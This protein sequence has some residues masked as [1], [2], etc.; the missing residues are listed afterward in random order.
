MD[1]GSHSK[2]AKTIIKISHLCYVD[3]MLLFTKASEI[4]LGRVL[5]CLKLFIISSS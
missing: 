4:Q 2:L 1:C 3:D 5:H